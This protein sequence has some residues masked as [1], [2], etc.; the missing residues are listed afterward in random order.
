MAGLGRGSLQS[1]AVAQ[2]T[3]GTLGVRWVGD[4]GCLPSKSLYKPLTHGRT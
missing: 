1:Y 2:Q 4:L 3:G